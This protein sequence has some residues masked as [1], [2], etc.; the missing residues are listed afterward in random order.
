LGRI[1]LSDL[2]LIRTVREKRKEEWLP[3]ETAYKEVLANRF[4]IVL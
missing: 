3:S 4:G 2:L 1:T